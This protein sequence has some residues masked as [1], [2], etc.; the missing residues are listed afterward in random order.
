MDHSEYLPKIPIRQQ[1]PFIPWTDNLI[2]FVAYAW[3][4]I[5]LVCIDVYAN[6]YFIKFRWC[7]SYFMTKWNNKIL[8]RWELLKDHISN[9]ILFVQHQVIHRVGYMNISQHCWIT[10]SYVGKSINK[11]IN[12]WDAKKSNFSR[13][14]S[15][16]LLSIL[17]GLFFCRT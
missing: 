16:L 11:S 14:Y 9:V 5:L 17:I 3:T 1:K 8:T 10:C 6:R 12:Q 2:H 7:N 15:I 13:A 4:K